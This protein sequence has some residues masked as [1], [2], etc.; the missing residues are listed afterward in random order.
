MEQMQSGIVMSRPIVDRTGHIPHATESVEKVGINHVKK[1][2]H[3][4]DS[5]RPVTGG[6]IGPVV[7]GE[8][9]GGNYF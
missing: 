7:S 2:Q 1:N 4:P 9:V 5:G 6:S 3:D 8:P